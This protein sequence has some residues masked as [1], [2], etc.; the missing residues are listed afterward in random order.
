MEE[1][2]FDKVDGEDPGPTKLTCKG[3]G[4][5]IGDRY[6][7]QGGLVICERCRSSR[8]K[9]LEGSGARR[10]LRAALYG[11]V[12]AAIGAGL[13]YAVLALTGYEIGFVSI[14][15]GIIVGLGV[16]KGSGGVGGWPY[17]SLAIGL[18]Y[19]S[20]TVTY[21]P[22]VFKE[23]TKP[24][25]GGSGGLVAGSTTAPTVGDETIIA[26][27]ST[28]STP[29]EAVDS[30]PGGL[31]GMALAM[32]VGLIV[33][34]LVAM[35]APILAGFDNLLGILII[36]FGLYEAWK[37]NKRSDVAILG[38]FSVTTPAP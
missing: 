30:P 37:I 36:G 34:V 4:A 38:P 33:L 19:L 18:T 5:S 28:T 14:V 11:G 12:A 6:W 17:Q 15:V 1:L 25:E 10:F 9:V 2:K 21:V 3:C 24:G 7:Q 31:L 27:T 23:F 32:S 35:A 20:I 8:A 26:A 16:K 13:Y 29:S 22:M